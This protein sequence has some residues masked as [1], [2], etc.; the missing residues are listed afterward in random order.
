MIYLIFL[1]IRKNVSFKQI[2]AQ[3]ID[4]DPLSLNFYSEPVMEGISDI[5]YMILLDDVSVINAEGLHLLKCKEYA[6]CRALLF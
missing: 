2:S 5:V 1:L 3:M 6:F 4:I